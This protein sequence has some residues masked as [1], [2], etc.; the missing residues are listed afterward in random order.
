VSVELALKGTPDVMDMPNIT[1]DVTPKETDG[2][3]V[4]GRD[5]IFK[6]GRKPTFDVLL[7]MGDIQ[8]E[9]RPAEGADVRRFL[10]SSRCDVQG[11]PRNR[12]PL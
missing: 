9:T 8:P 5:V 3:T 4:P 2:I 11:R 6:S 1:C 7:R 12:F 10:S